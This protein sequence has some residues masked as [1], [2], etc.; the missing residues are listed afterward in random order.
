MRTT[1]TPATEAQRRE[2]AAATRHA[3]LTARVGWALA[4][5]LEAARLW[6]G[7]ALRDGIG[8]PTVAD[9][10]ERLTQARKLTAE[11]FTEC[12]AAGDEL[13]AAMADAEREARV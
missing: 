5:E 9:A 3:D 10:R 13:L 11:L 7:R 1:T 6:A 12:T 8:A 2:V 4:A